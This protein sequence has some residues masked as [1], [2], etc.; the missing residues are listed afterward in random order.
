MNGDAYFQDEMNHTKFL[1][2]DGLIH[3]QKLHLSHFTD[4]N[5]QM[6]SLDEP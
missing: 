3:P 1:T 5:T 4:T 6:T 2:W